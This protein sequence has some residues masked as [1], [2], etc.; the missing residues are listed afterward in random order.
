MTP[1]I[2]AA[3]VVRRFGK[4]TALDGLNLL[5]EQGAILA[6]LGPNGAGKTT[7]VRCIATLIEPDSGTLRVFGH[8]VV[9]EAHSVRSSIGLA[10]QLA[11]VEPAMT[12]REN[13]EMV[14]RLFGQD[15]ARARANSSRVLEQIGLVEDADRLVRTYSGGMRRKLDLGASLVGVPRLLLLDEPTTGVDP[16]SR[17]DLWDAMRGLVEQGTNVLLTTQYLDEADHLAD[18]IVI[19][20]HGRTIAQGTPAELKKRAGHQVIEVHVRA[21]EDVTEVADALH[22]IG[23]GD[24]HVDESARRVSVV[25]EGGTEQLTRA[26][27]PLEHRGHRQAEPAQ[28]PSDSAAVLDGDG[29]GSDVPADLPLHLRRRDWGGEARLRGLRHTRH[30]HHGPHL[31]GDGHCRGHHR[32]PRPGS[33][34]PPALPADPAERRARGSCV[35]RHG[36]AVLGAHR[37]DDGELPRR[38][39]ARGRDRECS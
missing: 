33:V 5:A 16:R 39:P 27:R 26:L 30:P 9:R 22:A 36:D 23:D 14:A 31:A 29:A 2:E 8:D 11:A 35:C 19:I 24:V 37:H 3:G 7:F 13:L 21:R 34:R 1:M 15:R 12:G 4:T 25:V 17:I 38:V 18:E 20:D 10:G 28:V 32:G 6:V